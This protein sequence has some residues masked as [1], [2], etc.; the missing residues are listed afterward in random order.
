[1][2]ERIRAAKGVVAAANQE[3]ERRL[4]F[5][6]REVVLRADFDELDGES[7]LQ[8]PLR[9]LMDGP[10]HPRVGEWVYLMDDKG[11]GCLGCVEEVDGWS[12]RV[13]PDWGSWEGDKPPPLQ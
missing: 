11:S 2:P 13:R 10:R 4:D 3:E 7:C 5:S 6:E 12:A 1:M 9:F 8:L